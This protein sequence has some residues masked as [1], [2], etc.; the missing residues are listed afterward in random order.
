MGPVR[1]R[2][3]GPRQEGQGVARHLR[4]RRGRGT[5]LRRRGTCASR[6]Q[7]KD[8]FPPLPA[9]LLPQQLPRLYRRRRFSRSPVLLRRR[10]SGPPETDVQ[11]HEQHCRVLQRATTRRT[12]GAAG[13]RRSEVPPDAAGGPR[14]LPQRLRL[15]VFG[16]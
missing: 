16:C 4:H 1:C 9:T 5:C 10:V 11:R 2:D 7:G 15:V 6:T 12:A 14:G 8:Q 13:D 3:Q